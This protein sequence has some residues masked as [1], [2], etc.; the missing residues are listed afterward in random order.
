MRPVLAQCSMEFLKL[1]RVE[2]EVTH[3]F[4]DHRGNEK[5]VELEAGI[6]YV[7]QECVGYQTVTVLVATVRVTVDCQQSVLVDWHPQQ[8]GRA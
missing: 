4:S 5:I 6:L 3:Q 8:T 1:R 7:F 2:F